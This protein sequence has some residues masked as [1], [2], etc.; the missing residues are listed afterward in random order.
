M[1]LLTHSKARNET[2]ELLIS[3]LFLEGQRDLTVVGTISLLKQK[4]N[5]IQLLEIS[6][7]NSIT[8]KIIQICFKDDYYPRS[9]Y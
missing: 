6:I 7:R 5:S 3:S 1:F 4:N 2:T 8:R 9:C